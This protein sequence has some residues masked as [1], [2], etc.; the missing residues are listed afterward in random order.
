MRFVKV[1]RAKMAKDSAI[2]LD[3]LDDMD[4]LVLVVD[5]RERGLTVD[6][7]T[8]SEHHTGR[9]TVRAVDHVSAHAVALR[10]SGKDTIDGGDAALYVYGGVS[11][12]SVTLQA[13]G[14][15]GWWRI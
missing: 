2:K 1:I 15:G 8:A 11:D 13:D 10:P 12:D 3:P 14:D 5:V 7:P 6:L 9:V 4:E